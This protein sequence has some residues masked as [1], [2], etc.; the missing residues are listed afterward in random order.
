[1]LGERVALDWAGHAPGATAA[2]AE[3]E[4]LDLD[5]LD[6]CVPEAF[7]RLDVAVVG[8]DDAW[9]ERE[10][11]VAVVPLLTLGLVAVAPRLDE[12]DPGKSER[13][14]DRREEVVIGK[15]GL[16]V[17]R[18]ENRGLLLPGVATEHGFDAETFLTHTCLKANLPSVAWREEETRIVEGLN[19][20][21]SGK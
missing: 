3:L 7:V 11:V 6:P 13:T 16:I 20:T 14:S 1:M 5:H 18:G 15:H 12:S 21:E 8:D 9:L 2:A 17:E 4:A 10:D 19:E